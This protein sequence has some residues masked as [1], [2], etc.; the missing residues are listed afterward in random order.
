VFSLVQKENG[1]FIGVCGCKLDED[2]PLRVEVIIHLAKQAWGKGYA[3]EAV[4]SY[5][6]WLK[7]T[8]KATCVYGSVHPDNIA[9]QNMMEKCGF[10]H[11]GYVQYEDTGF[12]DEPYF[13]MYLDS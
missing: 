7:R 8:G 3:T 5:I 11:N 4:K 2:D 13:E 6:D 9:S 12:V 10:V 1:A